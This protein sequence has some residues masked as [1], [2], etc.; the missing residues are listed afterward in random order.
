MMTGHKGMVAWDK[1]WKPHHLP[2]WFT[3]ACYKHRA[4]LYGC[5]V[6]MFGRDVVSLP[7]EVFDHYGSV[8][9]GDGR[10]LVSQP[11]SLDPKLLASIL[12]HIGCESVVS[13]PGPWHPNTVLVDIAPPTSASRPSC[14]GVS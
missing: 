12:S 8:L 5:G 11:Y 2:R 10:H 7:T 6:R 9:R 4:E 14:S 13:S 1:T 3:E